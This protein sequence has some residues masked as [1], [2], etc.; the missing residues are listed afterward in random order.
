MTFLLAR[1]RSPWAT[2][3]LLLLALV[4]VGGIYA[5]GVRLDR[6]PRPPRRR[7]STTLIE[8]GRELFLEGC[9]SCHG[10]NADGGFQPDGTVAGPV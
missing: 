4:A 9:S 7:A 2:A 8:E 1:R 5:V 3:L 6:R 10:V